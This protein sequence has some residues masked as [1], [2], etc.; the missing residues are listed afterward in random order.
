MTSLIQGVVF[1][2]GVAVGAIGFVPWSILKSESYQGIVE[3]SSGDAREMVIAFVVGIMSGGIV[4]WIAISEP[5]RLAISAPLSGGLGIFVGT[6]MMGA[7]AVSFPI[8]YQEIL[9]DELAD[10]QSSDY[11]E[12]GQQDDQYHDLQ[13]DELQEP[14]ED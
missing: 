12:P 3:S 9:F 6:M 2:V 4:A 10:Q 13:R 14:A 5:V 1:F 7:Y 8:E 11:E